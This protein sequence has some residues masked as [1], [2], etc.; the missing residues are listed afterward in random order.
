MTARFEI[1]NTSGEEAVAF[2]VHFWHARTRITDAQ[3]AGVSAIETRN[4][5]SFLLRGEVAADATAIVDVD[6]DGERPVLR[7]ATFWPRDPHEEK[8][9]GEAEGAGLQELLADSK[10]ADQEFADRRCRLIE[11]GCGVAHYF[12]L[13]VD[14]ATHWGVAA[15]AS[16]QPE[17]KRAMDMLS[18]KL[19]ARAAAA[20]E[21]SRTFEAI[22]S[23][24]VKSVSNLV[25]PIVRRHFGSG[26]SFDAASFEAAFCEFAGSALEVGRGLHSRPDSTLFFLFAELALV[27]LDYDID[28][29]VWAP[30]MTGLVASA[31][32]F[33]VIQHDNEQPRHR[34]S[35]GYDPSRKIDP[36]RADE[37]AVVLA[38]T[39]SHCR[40]LPE[41][42]GRIVCSA[43]FAWVHKA[44]IGTH[45]NAKPPM[46]L[47][48]S[49]FQS[50]S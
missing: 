36:I 4:G 8:F 24:L 27:A 10:S 32:V 21:Q 2:T 22:P 15:N 47:E 41:R 16:I 31:E 29:D 14:L 3:T 39:K 46:T 48:R 1:E 26:K 38:Q 6:F 44:V 13:D 49:S 35:Y 19:D 5:V 40:D 37:I 11:L 43:W 45:R 50:Q 28:N 17:L 9:L 25:A 42:F 23:D 7:D 34:K 18:S 12:F 33:A 30:A 20:A